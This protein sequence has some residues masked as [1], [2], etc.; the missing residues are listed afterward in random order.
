MFPNISE[1]AIKDFYRYTKKV[2]SR[3]HIYIPRSKLYDFLGLELIRLGS[4]SSLDSAEAEIEVE[5][6]RLREY[7]DPTERLHKTI[8]FKLAR[9]YLEN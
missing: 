2:K 9:Y 4:Q 3:L 6:V 8:I 5:N 7:R 1:T